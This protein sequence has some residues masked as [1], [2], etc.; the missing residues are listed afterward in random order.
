MGD[1]IQNNR[2]G[3]RFDF[4]FARANPNYISH[5]VVVIEV[6]EDTQGRFA[7]CV[8]GNESDSVRRT[9]VRLNANGLIKQR[10]GNSFISV[11]KNLK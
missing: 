5:S 11:V 3:N 9:V 8:G 4:A 1:I 6:G 2:E 10:P 7:F